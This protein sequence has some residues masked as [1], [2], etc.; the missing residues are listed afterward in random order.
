MIART[1]EPKKASSANRR[2]FRGTYFARS[3]SSSRSPSLRPEE[4]QKSREHQEAAHGEGQDSEEHAHEKGSP[5]HVSADGPRPDYAPA[6][7]DIPEDGHGD[8]YPCERDPAADKEEEPAKG[9]RWRGGRWEFAHR[10]L[11]RTVGLSGLS[12]LA[13]CELSPLGVHQESLRL[14]AAG[15]RS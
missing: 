4:P 15:L 10:S 9:T 8:R 13:L 7:D 1:I 11:L 2:N 14:A 12:L 5:P 6:G 3:A